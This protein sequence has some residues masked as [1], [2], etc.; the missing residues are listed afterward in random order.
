MGGLRSTPILWSVQC[1][2]LHLAEKIRCSVA[3]KV[4]R[5]AGRFWLR[6]STLQNLMGSIRRHILATYSSASSRVAPRDISSTNC[7]RGTGRQLA[8]QLAKLLP[9]EPAPPPLRT[10]PD[11]DSGD[12]ARQARPVAAR[13]N[14]RRRHEFI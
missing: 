13:P 4:V 3:A 2:R 11:D 1:V 14:R 9:H 5:K 8:R 10:S 6:F 12:A 7:W